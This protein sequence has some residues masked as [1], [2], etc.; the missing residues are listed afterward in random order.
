MVEMA[1]VEPDNVKHYH[2]LSN[3]RLVISMT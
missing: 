1:G 2:T 3:I